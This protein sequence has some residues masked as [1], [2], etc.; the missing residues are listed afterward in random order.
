MPHPHD[1]S[2][3]SEVSM[4]AID[5]GRRA[6]ASRGAGPVEGWPSG[7]HRIHA[8]DEFGDPATYEPRDYRVTARQ[9][10]GA[11]MI[12]LSVAGMG[13]ALTAKRMD[14]AGSASAA[15]V[16]PAASGATSYPIAGLRQPGLVFYSRPREIRIEAD[17]PD[18][19]E[20]QRPAED[21]C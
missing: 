13:L 8:E 21:R 17:E 20:R 6:T 3:M 11:W 2:N 5:I 19:Q 15:P 7:G 4:D 18:S 10:V 1:P 14:L 16:R 9:I 12:L